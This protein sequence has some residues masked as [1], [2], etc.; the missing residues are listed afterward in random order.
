LD[1]MSKYARVWKIVFSSRK[2]NVV[3]FRPGFSPERGYVPPHTHGTLKLTNFSVEMS[4]QY[5]Y[6][7]VVLD[8]CLTFIP[9][10]RDLIKRLA[11]TTHIISRLV[12]RDHT[13]SIPVIQTLVKTVLIPKMV[14]GFAF[15]PPRILRNEVINLKVTGIADGSSRMNMHKALKKAVLWPIMRSMGQ[16]YYVHHDSL[17]VE[18]R[19]L[20]LPSLHSLSCIRLAHRWMSNTLDATNEAGRMFRQHASRPPSNRS[21][22]HP[23][24]H[25]RSNITRILALSAFQH[26]PLSILDL[27]KHRLKE[28][29]WQQQYKEWVDTDTHPLH[30]QYNTQAPTQR[31][32]PTY[33]HM[34][35]PGAATTRA[36]LR[37][38]RARLKVDQKRLKFPDVGSVLCRQCGRADETVKHVLEV[39]DAPA[40]VDIRNR[41][42]R[43]IRKLCDK[44]GERV[45]DMENVLNPKAKNVKAL[46]KAHK[47]T[48]RMISLL[49]DIWDF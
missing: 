40:V 21:G 23:F 39:C 10:V 12:K 43:K 31:I 13:P 32:M 6:L 4:Q 37:F 47:V 22:C 11:S 41:M 20:S 35:T 42:H 27:E 16:P 49:R 7:G 28:V 8:Q 19:L 25:I 18:S 26:R 17:L 9:H 2:T 45:T 29:V 1:D 14:Y 24:F 36:R 38:A 34:D 33:T 5:T 3:Y 46:K 44:Y 48:G 15:V 30:Q